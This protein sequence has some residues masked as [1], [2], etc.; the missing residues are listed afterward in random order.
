MGWG[1]APLVECVKV[2]LISHP[3]NPTPATSYLPF[4][5]LHLSLDTRTVLW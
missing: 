5:L 3:R 1:E 4:C 2:S